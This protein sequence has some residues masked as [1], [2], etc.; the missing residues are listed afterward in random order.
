MMQIQGTDFWVLPGCALYFPLSQGPGA[1]LLAAVAVPVPRWPHSL[2]QD[3]FDEQRTNR[4]DIY[5]K[6]KN[7]LTTQYMFCHL[8][9]KSSVPFQ[10]KVCLFFKYPQITFVSWKEISCTFKFMKTKC[11]CIL[12][13]KTT[14]STSTCVFYF[15]AFY[16]GISDLNNNY[17]SDTCSIIK[18]F[19]N[20]SNKLTNKQRKR[21]QRQPEIW[22]S[23]SRSRQCWLGP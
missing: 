23:W 20:V 2:P 21:R 13:L 9:K 12:K 18:L 19:K 14:N 22:W 16:S 3:S 8:K 15:E 6:H 1:L 17:S 5:S 10:K 4:F 7:V 11:W